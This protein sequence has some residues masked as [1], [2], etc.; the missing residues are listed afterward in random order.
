M[1]AARQAA[2]LLALL[3]AQSA[4]GTLPEPVRKA[5]AAASI[6]ADR[7]SVWVQELG[8][9]RPAVEHNAGV[10]MNPASVIK[11]VTTYSA[12][13][14]L[15]PAHV[16]KTEAWTSAPVAADVLQGDLVLRGG[17]DPKLT[18]ESFWLMLRSLRGRGIREIRGDLVLDRSWIEAADHDPAKFDGQPTQPY[19]VGPDALLLNF[20]AFR[21]WFLPDLERRSVS[22][23]S[24]P[25]STALTLKSDLKLVDAACG[26]WRAGI[27][28][29]FN[30]SPFDARASFA[31]TYP[32][33]CGDRVWNVALLPHPVYVN[34]VF[35]RLWSELGGSITGGLREGPVPPGARL[36]HR[37]ESPPLTEVVRDINKFSNN[38]MARQLF[39][40]LSAEIVGPPGRHD[41][42]AAVVKGWAEQKGLRMPELVIENGSGLSR[43]ERISAASMG[44]MLVRAYESAV[45][46][47]FISS[48][49]L[50]AYDG[51]MRRR[52]KLES[53]AG[54]AHIKT[55]SLT[56]V[57]TVA[58]YVLDQGGRRHA[59]AFFINH[60]NAANGQAAQD[61]LLRWIY[62][63]RR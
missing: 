10:S 36:L 56:G 49:P 6:P 27:K 22:V 45:M 25:P 19:N 16:W 37:H 8:A 26:D 50:V 62:E 2:L 53:V 18:M 5:L 7:A 40:G 55:G 63:G 60:P 4:F 3:C 24:E 9:A 13:E 46:P 17:G 41:R 30:A 59:V 1:S 11:L 43:D 47:E 38:V 33:S 42:S 21:F 28:A 39:L 35:R 34:G 32:A 15:G 20:K 58:G 54:Q 29:E 61:A 31:G 57:R 23:S 44:R 12:L 51:T 52:L 14:L 48:M